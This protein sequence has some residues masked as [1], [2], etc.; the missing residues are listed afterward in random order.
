MVRI[1][2]ISKIFLIEFEVEIA[3][4]SVKYKLCFRFPTL[5]P[6]AKVIHSK[7]KHKVKSIEWQSFDFREHFLDF[8]K[9][10]MRNNRYS[11]F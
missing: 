10:S 4:K 6:F 2:A 11:I 9:V 1:S 5:N 7:C 3:F 8:S